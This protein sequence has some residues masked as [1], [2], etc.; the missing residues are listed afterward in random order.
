VPIVDWLFRNRLTGEITIGQTPNAPLIVFLVAWMGRRLLHPD[1]WIGTALA[2]V[3]T[4]AL[5]FWAGDEL[6]RGVNPWRRFLGA[7]VLIW[8]ARRLL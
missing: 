8:E 3:E 1:G 5:V 7:G 2:T 4:I 6:F